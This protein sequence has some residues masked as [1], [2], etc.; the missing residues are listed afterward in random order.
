MKIFSLDLENYKCH[1]KTS[2]PS[3]STLHVLVGRNSS[4]K[5]SILNSFELIKDYNELEATKLRGK[6]FGGVKSNEDKEIRYK[7]GIELS[8][9]E[10]KRYLFDYFR[11]SPD[12]ADNTSILEKIFMHFIVA[13][14][15]EKIAKGHHHNRI[16]LRK[17]EITDTKANLVTILKEDDGYHNKL[18]L[19]TFQKGKGPGGQI[20]EFNQQYAAIDSY[21]RHV[22]DTNKTP[23]D[24][25][26][27][28]TVTSM[29]QYDFLREF[30]DS[31]H[32]ID[33]F[34]E[35]SKEVE[36][37]SIDPTQVDSRGSNLINSM[38]TMYSKDS[39][40]YHEIEQICKRIFPDIKKI[41]PEPLTGKSITLV[42]EKNDISDKI[43]IYHEASGLD[44]LLI[45]IWKIATSEPGSIW[46]LDEP[47]LHLHPGAQQVLYDFLREESNKGKQI[48]IAT[49]SMVFMHNSDFDEVTLVLYESGVARVI[50]L[51]DLLPG[52]EDLYTP[53]GRDIVRKH[54]YDALGYDPTFAFEPRTVVVTE[55]Q[56]DEKILPIF[57][58]IVTGKPFDHG[59]TR[60]IPLGSSDNVEKYTPVLAFTVLG[61]KCLIT[62]DMTTKILVV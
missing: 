2:I 35:T 38:N 14:A 34:R 37:E 60:F 55:G 20:P 8:N 26:A 17:M 47:E 30:I 42:I 25:D 9:E 58:E 54:I 6:V 22:M 56:T 11:L 23:V 16:I 45:I 46:L 1:K 50:Q 36:Y 59:A 10:R 3:C 18:N 31:F 7:I 52:D 39:E 48:I 40:R 44:Q 5:S 27:L 43:G 57:S 28:N 51:R 15:G 33:S 62:L 41:H 24:A 49:H 29:F 32:F 21:L 12:L 19:A 53:I 61:K 4:G 13:V